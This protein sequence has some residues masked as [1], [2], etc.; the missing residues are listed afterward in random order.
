MLL[1][2][3]SASAPAATES[4]QRAMGP[5]PPVG[6]GCYGTGAFSIVMFGT[7][8]WGFEDNVG[9]FARHGFVRS[10]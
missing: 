5:V 8:A 2:V 1:A 6:T 9:N 7:I 4:T 3:L 10:A